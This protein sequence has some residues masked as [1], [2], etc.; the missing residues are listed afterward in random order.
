MRRTKHER[1][2]TLVIIAVS[3]L[4][5]TGMAGLALDGGRAYAERREMQNAADSAAMAG[6][7]KLD[8]YL[9]G[10]ISDAGAIADA[11]ADTA[12]QNGADPGKVTCQLVTFARAV[13]EPCPT[14]ATMSPATRLV[15][16]G[17]RVTTGST[18]E[19]FFM[20]ALGNTSFTAAADATAQIGRP[21]GPY[22]APFLVCA[23]APGH[24]PQILIPDLAGPEGFSVNPAAIGVTYDL[25]GNEIRQDGKDCGNDSS[26]YRGNV[27][28]DEN[29][30]DAPSY[31]I[32]GSWDADTGN[33]NGPTVRLVNSGTACSPDYTVGCVLVLPLCPRGNGQTGSGF[34]MFCSDLGLFQITKVENHDVDGTFLGRAT[35][36]TG[37]IVGPADAN[38]ARIVALT[39]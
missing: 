16:A 27:C 18:Q 22:V 14:S 3:A 8:L 32:P 4:T 6:T 31:S 15:A 13:I 2:A 26:S 36:N 10:V 21:G 19:T 11:V 12:E 23:T 28:L 17:V 30:C 38:G 24:V 5:L 37:G 29:S 7:R 39:D 34:S 20:R 35:V 25:Y 1:G 33:A 9:T